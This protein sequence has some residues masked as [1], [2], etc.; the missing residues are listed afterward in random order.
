MFTKFSSISQFREVRRNVEWDTQY[1][2]MDEEGHPIMDRTATL[3]TL[4][5]TGTVKIHGCFDENTEVSLANGQK[6]KIKNLK[7]GD[8]VLS[9]NIHTFEFEDRSVTAV[10]FQDLK[11]NWVK[12]TFDS[13]MSLVCTEDHKIYTKNRGWVNAGGVNA[14][15]EFL[16]DSEEFVP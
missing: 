10:I 5:Y 12:L 4:S 6:C 7:V 8:A 14:G 11:K 2:G 3:P 1:R 9:Y 15:D 13:G 16:E